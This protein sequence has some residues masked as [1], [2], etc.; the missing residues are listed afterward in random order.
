MKNRLS[1]CVAIAL[2]V[3]TTAASAL[4]GTFSIDQVYSSADGTFQF[5]VILDRGSSDCDAGEQLWAGQKLISSGSAP[6]RTFVFPTN[7]PSCK[8][9]KKRML[10][11]T[12]GFAAL[13]L[14]APDYVIP[15]GFLQIPA[16][17]VTF[18]GVSE[19]TYAALP[20][21]GVNALYG[22]GTVRQNLATNFAGASVSVVSLPPTTVTVIEYR[23]ASFDHY[24]ITPVAAE[25]AL[26]D[27]HAPPFQDWSR[28]GQ[29]FK[30]YVNALAPAG[31]VAI[32]RFFND[33]FAPKSSHFYG[34]R[35]GSCD[36]T[37]ALFPGWKLE[38][39]KLFNA[40][41]S[42]MA[43]ACPMGTIPVFRFY[44]NGVGGAPNHRFVASQ[45]ERQNMINQGWTPEGNGIG[46][47]TC[48]P[49]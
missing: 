6:D 22:D 5:V 21:D 3:I 30:V 45:T 49:A 2:A 34:P 20:T 10:I 36:V 32:C 40:M 33:T 13:G 15:N 48:V 4:P 24:F 7:L 44:N 27:A 39:D 12:E 9:S 25:I 11:A 8:T 46:V 16:G 28:T 31:S 1:W 14:I 18:A 29:S 47:E 19:V 17:G 35:G 26:L 38:D 37:I 42:D 41:L 23:H 43:G